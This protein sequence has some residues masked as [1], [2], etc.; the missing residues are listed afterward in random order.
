VSPG[1]RRRRLTL[2][3][4]KICYHRRRNADARRFHTKTRKALLRELGIDL[5]TVRRCPLVI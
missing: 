3:R 5:R 4:D 1:E 2:A